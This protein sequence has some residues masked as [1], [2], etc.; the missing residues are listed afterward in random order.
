MSVFVC[1]AI[2]G[3]LRHAGIPVPEWFP[4]PS[5]ENSDGLAE[6]FG[7]LLFLWL[8]LTP[9]ILIGM[10]MIAGVGV[11]LFGRIEITIQAD[12]DA[13][14]VFSGVGNIGRTR[15]FIPS[16]VVETGCTNTSWTFNNEHQKVVFFRTRDGKMIKFGTLLPENRRSFLIYA[17]KRVLSPDNI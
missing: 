2:A 6:G 16:Q 1:L 11:S 13:G 5:G 8:F 9:F 12:T 4:A 14:R 10:T 3:T 7:G 17:L 15:K